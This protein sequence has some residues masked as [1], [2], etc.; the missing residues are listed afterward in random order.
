M[1]FNWFL[2][3]FV[4]VFRLLK[5]LKIYK[6][7]SKKAKCTVKFKFLKVIQVSLKFVKEQKSIQWIIRN[8][9][10]SHSSS[11]FQRY[12]MSYFNPDCCCRCPLDY[13]SAHLF[14]VEF[15]YVWASLISR[16]SLCCTVNKKMEFLLEMNVNLFKHKTW[17][18]N[19]HLYVNVCESTS[20]RK[21]EMFYCKLCSFSQSV[22]LCLACCKTLKDYVSNLLKYKTLFTNFFGKMLLLL[23]ANSV[24]VCIFCTCLTQSPGV[25][26]FIF[27]HK[28]Q[29]NAAIFSVSSSS[30]RLLFFGMFWALS[31]EWLSMCL[32]KSAG[33]WKTQLQISHVRGAYVRS[34]SESMESSFSSKCSGLMVIISDWVTSSAPTSY[35]GLSSGSSFIAR[36]LKASGNVKSFWR[37]RGG[38][39]F[40]GW[41]F[42][43]LMYLLDGVL[44][45]TW[46]D[47]ACCW[48]FWTTRFFFSVYLKP[49]NE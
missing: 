10:N 5:I 34:P 3:V 43:A 29:L 45:R 48:L 26:K 40:E 23:I 14:G 28:S 35:S 30:S 22:L 47:S 11:K 31:S 39:G 19:I 27:S 12:F 6:V 4:F 25:A 49:I 36:K 9:W 44:V 15:A 46:E 33:S 7:L 41:P 8:V 20:M 37:G 2:V 38:G 24:S 1:P 16:W 13:H 17:I 42:S 32:T 18:I 21:M